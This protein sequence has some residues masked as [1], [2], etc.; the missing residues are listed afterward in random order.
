MENSDIS[1]EDLIPDSGPGTSTAAYEESDIS[2]AKSQI[3]GGSLLY[4][5]LLTLT[6]T[7]KSEHHTGADL[8]SR[9]IEC[10]NGRLSRTEVDRDRCNNAVESGRD[11]PT[12][13]ST[14]EEGIPEMFPR[15]ADVLPTAILVTCCCPVCGFM[16]ILRAK[17]ARRFRQEG[18]YYASAQVTEAST[19][20]AWSAA[21]SGCFI[22]FGL[23]LSIMIF[24][25]MMYA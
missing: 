3:K 21:L 8:E 17:Q 7:E 22:L 16:A 10:K 4:D 23:T 12:T 14:M 20:W 6:D 15:D 13:P 18:K 5:R 24:L 9:H 11:Q 19:W 2:I 25:V 1:Q